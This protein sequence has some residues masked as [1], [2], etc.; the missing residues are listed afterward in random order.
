MNR[1]PSEDW[2]RYHEAEEQAN[3]T[4]VD[5][6]PD[7]AVYIGDGED[8]VYVQTAE[9]EG[10]WYVTTVVDCNTG[11]FCENGLTDDGPYPTEDEAA[12]AGVEYAQ[13]WCWSNDVSFDDDGND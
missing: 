11:S 3:T 8:G 5:F 6:D 4:I 9:G 12:G 2:N 7:H 10:G 13:D 1:C